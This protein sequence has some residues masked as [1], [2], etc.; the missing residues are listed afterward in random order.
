MKLACTS[1]RSDE[2]MP[3]SITIHLDAV[4]LWL[5]LIAASLHIFEEFVWP[6]G[7][8]EWYRR[9]DPAA[10][11]GVTTRFLV[12]INLLL[13][14]LCAMPPVLG[15]TARGISFWLSASA[16]CAGNALFHVYA[17]WRTRIYSPGVV[18]GVLLYLPIAVLGFTIYLGE[19]AATPATAIQAVLIGAAYVY[20]STW[21]RKRTARR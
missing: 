6:G 4:L 7:F 9:Y 3:P 17:T 15:A 2:S 13:L 5:P 10:A 1:S 20:W 19:G 21:R 11:A 16:V 8:A 12:G 14:A 18:T